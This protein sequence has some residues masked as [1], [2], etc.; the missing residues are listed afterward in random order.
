MKD[1]EKLKNDLDQTTHKA[2][3]ELKR[4]MA[5]LDVANT[6]LSKANTNFEQS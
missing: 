3:Q 4:V 5:E 1:W 6:D 2:E